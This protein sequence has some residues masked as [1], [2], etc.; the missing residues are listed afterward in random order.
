MEGSFTPQAASVAMACLDVL[1]VKLTGL[2]SYR[3][4]AETETMFTTAASLT[5]EEASS[6][7]CMMPSGKTPRE[8]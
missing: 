1:L 7:S 4:I 8:A 3:A 6:G 5:S 2:I